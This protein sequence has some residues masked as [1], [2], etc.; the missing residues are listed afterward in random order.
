MDNT[1]APM[2]FTCAFS[3][4][5]PSPT[6]QFRTRR[7]PPQH[8]TLQVRSNQLKQSFS[9][10]TFL[11]RHQ[12]FL[13]PKTQPPQILLATSLPHHRNKSRNLPKTRP[14]LVNSLAEEV[15]SLSL[16]RKMC[17]NLSLTSNRRC[18]SCQC[19]VRLLAL[20]ELLLQLA[21][22]RST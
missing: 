17:I 3:G 13:S 15:L 9:Y 16:S 22:S 8:P 19:K 1:L 2:M 6:T 4:C 18:P 14:R 7:H 11:K 10:Q 5:Q 20:G 12:P 21:I